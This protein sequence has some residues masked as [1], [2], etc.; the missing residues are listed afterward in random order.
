[1]RL[2]SRIYLHFLG[3]LLVVGLATAVVF[4]LGARSAF[5]GEVTERAARHVGSLVAEALADRPLLD[6]RLRQL[7]EDL[8]VDVTVRGLDGRVLAAAGPPLP[9]LTAAEGPDVRGGA[10]VVRGRTGWHAAAPV[11]DPASGAV[12]ATLHVSAPR[13]FRPP[14][15]VLRPALVAALVLVAVAVATRPL[16]RR[17]ARPLERLTETARRL[18]GGDLS[19]RVPDVARRP[20]RWWRPGHAQELVELTRAFNDMARRVE[21]MVRGQKELLANVSHELRS[22]LARIRLALELVPRTGDA[23]ARLRGV[24]ADLAELDGLIEDVLATARLDATGL[25]TRLGRVDAQRLLEDV[26]ERARHHP[27]TAG[28][29]IVVA[30][31]RPDGMVSAPRVEVGVS[32]PRPP[33]TAHPRRDP[34]SGS[35]TVTVLA[36][37]ALLRRALWNLVENA[38]KYGAP[39][40]TLDVVAAGA[41]VAFTVT[42]EGPGVPAEL[43][44]RV[45]EPFYRGDTA[46][47]P[48]G[49]GAAPRGVGLGLTLARRVAE[50][51]GGA[52]AIGPASTADGRER[53]CRVTITVPREA[54]TTPA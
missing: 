27:A 13:R 4:A 36:D 12:V 41:S 14:G 35:D 19:A 44:E 45:L 54:P 29:E 40:I 2:H 34:T 3:V 49:A 18:G 31:P 32:E 37:E 39:P 10:V 25:P 5:V 22:P 48:G 43:R 1:M 46:R 38:A 47:T 53:G 7:R 11:R 23:D 26:A 9:A 6:R 24:D 21:R 28:A 51:H 8:E 20:R 30:A 33:E 50:V 15:S 52:I 42:D 17:I 16:A